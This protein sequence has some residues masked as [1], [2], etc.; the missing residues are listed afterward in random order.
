MQSWRRFD[1]CESG[2]DVGLG[3]A[4]IGDEGERLFEALDRRGLVLLQE[5]RF[6]KPNLDINRIGHAFQNGFEVLDGLVGTVGS[7]VGGGS[8]HPRDGILRIPLQDP[9]VS[10]DGI[11]DPSEV[12]EEVALALQEDF[13]VWLEDGKKLKMLKRHL[14]THYQMTPEQ[15]R[16]KWNLPADYPMV[17]PNYAEQRR[18]LAKKIGLGTTRR[19]A[20]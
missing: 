16:A 5:G 15:Y 12:E 8:I 6:R 10:A 3:G 9:V 20:R 17:A 1:R 14:M 4:G 2:G 18:T 19:K 11:V 7:E 13:I